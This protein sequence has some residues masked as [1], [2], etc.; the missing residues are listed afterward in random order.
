VD[1]GGDLRRRQGTESL[2]V[3][4]HLLLDLPED[5]QLPGREVDMR[6]PSGME[7]RPLFGQVLA[8]WQAS[9]VVAR[10]ADFRLG[11]GTEEG[12]GFLH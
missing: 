1:V 7:D 11:F 6:L 2:V 10:V 3:E 5:E 9:G 12:H 4:R 8:R